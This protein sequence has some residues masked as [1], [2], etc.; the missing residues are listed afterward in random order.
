MERKKKRRRCSGNQMR[1]PP[2]TMNCRPFELLHP[3]VVSSDE[4]VQPP[5]P[6]SVSSAATTAPLTWGDGASEPEDLPEVHAEEGLGGW[7]HLLSIKKSRRG[8]ATGLGRSSCDEDWVMGEEV[9]MA[10]FS[11]GPPHRFDPSKSSKTHI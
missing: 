8:R 1:R 9:G 10:L 3:A 11:G 2:L 6:A 7:R 5:P 4:H